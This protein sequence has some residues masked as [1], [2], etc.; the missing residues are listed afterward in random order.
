MAGC[1]GLD[2]A[3]GIKVDVRRGQSLPVQVET[4]GSEGL[5]V[6]LNVQYDKPLPVRVELPKVPVIALVFAALVTLAALVIAVVACFAAL[7]VVRSAEALRLSIKPDSPPPE[8]ETDFN[9][10]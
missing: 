3:E 8:D 4:Q 6:R 9:G 5:P 10:G 1:E 2:L 7:Y